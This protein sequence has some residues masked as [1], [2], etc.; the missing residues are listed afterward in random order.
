[1]KSEIRLGLIGWPLV[2]SASP[3]IFNFMFGEFGMKGKYE[4]FPLEDKNLEGF[5]RNAPGRLLGF[6]VTTP[7]KRKVLK[8]CGELSK[9]VS[10]TGA[11]NAIKVGGSMKAHNTDV[12]GFYRAYASKIGCGGTACIFGSGGAASA[13]ARVLDGLNFVRIHIVSRSPEKAELKMSAI[14]PKLLFS[15]DLPEKAD[16]YIN[17]TPFPR[18]YYKRID[19]KAI[20]A[21]LNYPLKEEKNF[22]DGSNMLFYQAVRSFSIF[23]E[24]QLSEE[25]EDDLFKRYRRKYA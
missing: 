9:E 16:I 19:E 11:A 3:E 20:Y 21:D 4:L 12:Y 10:L 15:A 8:F 22:F 18:I 25:E 17:A 1:M 13:A 6:N 7:H 5:F 2:K 14:S 23:L 24:L